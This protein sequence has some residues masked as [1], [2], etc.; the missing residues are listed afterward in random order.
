MTAL[1]P[2][3]QKTVFKTAAPEIVL[4]LALHVSR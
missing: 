4:E 3:P 2:N 1:A